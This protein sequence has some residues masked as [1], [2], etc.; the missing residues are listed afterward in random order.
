MTSLATKLNVRLSSNGIL[1]ADEDVKIKSMLNV[2][3]NNDDVKPSFG[4]LVR[5]VNVNA[6]A[7]TT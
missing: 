6:I 3:G 1:T 7:N 2:S 5:N 4:E